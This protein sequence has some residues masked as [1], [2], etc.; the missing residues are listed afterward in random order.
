MRGRLSDVDGGRGLVHGSKGGQLTQEIRPKSEGLCRTGLIPLT[1]PERP[2]PKF[3]D[4]NV[5]SIAVIHG[6]DW[7]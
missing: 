7:I 4:E 2:N 6:R 1:K 3:G 5:E